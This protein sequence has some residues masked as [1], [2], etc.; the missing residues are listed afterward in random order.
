MSAS[1]EF[2]QLQIHFTDPL[3]HEYELKFDSFI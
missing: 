1:E 2:D 3:Q